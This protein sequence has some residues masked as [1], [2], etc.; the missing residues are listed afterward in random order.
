MLASDQITDKKKKKKNS[1][2]VN[3]SRTKQDSVSE[4]DKLLRA[5]TQC[6]VFILYG[7]FK[8]AI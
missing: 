3:T 1:G 7:T 5:M 8:M 6:A 2:C 4:R